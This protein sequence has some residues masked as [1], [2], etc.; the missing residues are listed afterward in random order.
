MM[1]DVK[2]WLKDDKANNF[3]A[4]ISALISLLPYILVQKGMVHFPKGGLLYA[5]IQ[6][7]FV[8]AGLLVITIRYRAYALKEIE[9]DRA[10]RDYIEEEC[11]IEQTVSFTSSGASDVI[12]TI[13]KQFFA[14]WI[15][16][17]STWLLYYI[18]DMYYWSSFIN[19]NNSALVA[20][21]FGIKF[22]LD[23][24]GSAFVF[25][26]YLV[27]SEYTVDIEKRSGKRGISL[28]T[29]GIFL[30][31]VFYIFLMLYIVYS[32][33]PV[34]NKNY[35]LYNKVLLSAFGCIS[36]V[37]VLGK[38][39]SHYLNV[40]RPMMILLYIYAVSQAF[41]FL[42]GDIDTVEK[43]ILFVPLNHMANMVISWTTILGKIVLLIT[44]S[45]ILNNKR[46][47]FFIVKRSL[48]MTKIDDQLSEFNRYME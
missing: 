4:L 24:L 38:F 36:F 39:N 19:R 12:R 13:V 11:Q 41:S 31:V 32:S 16:V 7:L 25:V 14:I 47:I 2:N 48:S 23:F 29:N 43:D 33:N 5:T 28:F 30:V 21:L 1:E 6:V 9:D 27:M 17:W 8:L 46:L 3:W 26:L 45:W 42:T 37:L 34:Q 40:P 35:L 22:F 20:N 44:L 10:L 15:M 18:A